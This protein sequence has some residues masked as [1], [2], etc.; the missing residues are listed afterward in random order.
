MRYNTREDMRDEVNA[1]CRMCVRRVGRRAGLRG[2]LSSF[3]AAC[4][5]WVLPFIVPWALCGH[6]LSP[7][8]ADAGVAR[9]RRCSASPARDVA[10]RDALECRCVCADVHAWRGKQRV[11][12]LTVSTL[13]LI[14]QLAK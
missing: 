13:S 10:S 5:G 8:V 9:R 1:S 3:A 11:Y 2:V 14:W 12:T 4:W 6:L 7:N